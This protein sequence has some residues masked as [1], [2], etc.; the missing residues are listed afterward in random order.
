MP[1]PAAA[2]AILRRPAV[3]RLTGLSYSTIYR[4][5]RAGKFPARIRLGQNA[6]GWREADVLAWINSREP[7]PTGPVTAP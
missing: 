6:V 4:A 7:I 5:M 1:K 2:P 3:L